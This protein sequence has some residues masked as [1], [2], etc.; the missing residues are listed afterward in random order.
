MC[1]ELKVDDVSHLLAVQGNSI[2]RPF[3]FEGCS[4]GVQR[5]EHDTEISMFMIC[6]ERSWSHGFCALLT[7]A[8]T[9]LEV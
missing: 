1:Y 7:V 2:G 9:P 5:E 3:H 6:C 8:N 4:E